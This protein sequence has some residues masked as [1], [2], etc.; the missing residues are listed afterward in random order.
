MILNG[1]VECDKEEVI[2]FTSLLH[3]ERKGKLS[4]YIQFFR[5]RI[6]K[7]HEARNQAKTFDW[8]SRENR[9]EIPSYVYDD[10]DDDDDDDRIEGVA[11]IKMSTARVA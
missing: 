2:R 8:G 7:I 11:S 1:S 3:L 10:D 5:S 4:V 6:E 9:A